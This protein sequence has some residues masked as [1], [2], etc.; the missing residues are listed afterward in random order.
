M[1]DFIQVTLQLI[2][3]VSTAK[4]TSG[5]TWAYSN[6]Q[7]QKNADFFGDSTSG[8]TVSRLKRGVAAS[9]PQPTDDLVTVWLNGATSEEVELYREEYGETAYIGLDDKLIIVD[10]Y[11]ELVKNGDV[12]EHSTS[13]QPFAN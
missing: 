11:E 9:K 1:N 2:E 3:W 5:S 13:E 4:G 8:Y 12:E 10:E 6:R 7:P